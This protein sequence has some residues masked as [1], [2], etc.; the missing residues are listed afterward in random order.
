MQLVP[1]TKWLVTAT[2]AETARPQ[3]HALVVGV[4]DDELRAHRL[5]ALLAGAIGFRSVSVT[6]ISPSGATVGELVYEAPSVDPSYWETTEGTWEAW[7]A[8]DVAIAS[9]HIYRRTAFAAGVD[10]E[11]VCADARTQAIGERL[12][13]S[14][15]TF[16]SAAPTAD[17][18][19]CAVLPV[20]VTS[21]PGCP[22]SR[23]SVS[24][25]PTDP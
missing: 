21:L 1:D 24:N 5:A 10:W 23:E 12:G 14:P 6:R 20:E 25:A 4:L 2:V 18:G 11:I 16:A 9:W 7:H 17:D 8:H 15:R 19:P 13:L 3:T 22:A